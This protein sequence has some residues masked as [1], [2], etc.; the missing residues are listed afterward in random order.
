MTAIDLHV[1]ILDAEVVERAKR[2]GL[3]V[4]VYAPHFTRLPE[5]Q[6][7]AERY[8]DEDLLVLPARELFTGPWH[9]RRHVLAIG[10]DEP[11]PDFLSLETTMAELQRQDA[12]VLV[13][14][15]TFLSISLSVDDIR[16]Y[17]ACIDAIEV[18]NPKTLWYHHRRGQRLAGECNVGQFASSYA[19]L[20]WMVGRV[21]MEFDTTVDSLET[22]CDTIQGGLEGHVHRGRGPTYGVH[23]AI[24]IA[25]IGWENSWEKA[26]RVFR[27]G[28][29][30]THPRHP[31]YEERFDDPGY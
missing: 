3:D 29:E 10:L 4:V 17:V 5:I 7:A 12:A 2:H 25:H 6:R 26:Q 13:P 30:P 24:E 18:Y 22:L 27:P 19:H 23:R 14:H 21:W 8:S 1:K 28:V 15:P 9:N 11:V 31:A 20:R 16:H